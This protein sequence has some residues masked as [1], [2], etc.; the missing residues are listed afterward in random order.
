MGKVLFAVLVLGLLAVESPGFSYPLLSDATEVGGKDKLL[1]YAQLGSSGKAESDWIQSFFPCAT[2]SL[3]QEDFQTG[4]W[5]KVDYGSLWALYLSTRPDYFVIKTGNT[6]T[7]THYLF[8]NL[9]E[10]SWAVISLSD[11]D[12]YGVVGISKISHLDEVSAAPVP[13]PG[14]VLLLG[15]GLLGLAWYGRRRRE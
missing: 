13:E 8:E 6:G 15:G 3:K 2:I 14:T 9:D 12:I 4:D 10:P 7:Y 1:Q 5:Q 11:V